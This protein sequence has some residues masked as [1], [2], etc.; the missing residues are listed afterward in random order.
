LIFSEK[1]S[2]GIIRFSYTYAVIRWDKEIFWKEIDSSEFSLV[3]EEA[4]NNMRF[5][6]ITVMPITK[7]ENSAVV[8]EDFESTDVH[9]VFFGQA[10]LDRC[11]SKAKALFDD[12]SF[13]P[14][15]RYL[16]GSVWFEDEALG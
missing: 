9:E 15:G 13:E 6:D 4:E 12:P 7:T 3:I 11:V 1:T 16:E 5:A 10:Y 2:F 8:D 14:H